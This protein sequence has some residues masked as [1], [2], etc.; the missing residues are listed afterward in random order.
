MIV[1]SQKKD[2]GYHCINLTYKRNN[3]VKLELFNNMENCEYVEDVI[4]D[5][6]E[7]IFA[8]TQIKK[9]KD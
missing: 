7:L 9:E 1:E 6:D 8:L 3:Q 4:V 5:I 2:G